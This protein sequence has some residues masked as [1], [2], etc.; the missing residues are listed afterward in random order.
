MLGIY[1]GYKKDSADSSGLLPILAGWL[2][3]TTL[4][5]LLLNSLEVTG[6]FP[7]REVQLASG[8]TNSL[9]T[10]GAISV[11]YVIHTV[12]F[13]AVFSKIKAGNLVRFFSRN[14]IIVFIGHMPFY[15]VLEPIVRQVFA[16]GWPKRLCIVIIMFVGLSLLSEFLSKV[17]KVDELKNRLWKLLNLQAIVR[18]S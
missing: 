16:S 15:F 1:R 11:V 7:F 6:R 10:S 13:V 12:F 2:A 4:W 9:I 5:V 8:L 17:I 3:F 14:T 18:V